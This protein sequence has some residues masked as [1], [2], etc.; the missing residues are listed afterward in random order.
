L[1]T[2]FT[3]S[4]QP[5]L[6][7]SALVCSF[8]SVVFIFRDLYS[9]LT[10][11][12]ADGADISKLHL[13]TASLGIS[14]GMIEQTINFLVSKPDTRLV[15]VDT[16][17]CIRDTDCDS[18]MYSYDYRDMTALREITSKHKITL[19]LV[20]HTRKMHDP[21]PLNMLSGSTGL[22]GA[23]DGV[24]VLEKEKRTSAKAK[25]TIANRDTEDFCFKLEFDGDKG[26]W[27]FIGNE[28]DL[29]EEKDEWLC[30]LVDDFLKT[31]NWSGTATELCDAL[32]RIDPNAD[33]SKLNITKQL[34]GCSTLIR[35]EFGITVQFERSRSTRVISFARQSL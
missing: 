9:P 34:K 8:Q 14:T 30:L 16:L 31:D 35:K 11:I 13:A 25:L 4:A 22:V 6:H 23:V 20:H 1:K 19:M 28:A 2:A 24:F 17:Q 26:K 12:E 27:L 7:S 21:D 15:I 29:E 32:K 18:N 5:F 3:E 33:V 10:Q